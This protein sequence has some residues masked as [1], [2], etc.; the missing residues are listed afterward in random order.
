MDL[1]HGKTLH[2]LCEIQPT[3]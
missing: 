1:L 3:G 2:N